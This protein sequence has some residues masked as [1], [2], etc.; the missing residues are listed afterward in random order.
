MMILCILLYAF[1]FLS[2]KT[3]IPIKHIF[4]ACLPKWT[5]VKAT[6]YSNDDSMAQESEAA[7]RVCRYLIHSF[8]LADYSMP[9]LLPNG[10]RLFF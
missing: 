3:H 8:T 2:F 9:D 5:P 7:F 6:H 10:A 4:G 1:C